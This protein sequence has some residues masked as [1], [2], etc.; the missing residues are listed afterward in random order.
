MEVFCE[1]GVHRT[2]L[3]DRKGLQLSQNGVEDYGASENW[4]N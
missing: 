3:L 1:L 4:D 2:P